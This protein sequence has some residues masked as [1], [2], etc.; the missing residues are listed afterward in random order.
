M[1]RHNERDKYDSLT[2]CYEPIR[3][4]YAP[5]NGSP[6]FRPHIIHGGASVQYGQCDWPSR[7]VWIVVQDREP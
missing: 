5:E 1:L 6:Y 4:I 3:S 2:Q 7:S